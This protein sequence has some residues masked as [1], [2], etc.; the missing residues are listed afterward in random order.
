MPGA[1]A[2]LAP[3]EVLARRGAQPAIVV[4]AAGGGIQAAAWTA[5]VLAGLQHDAVQCHDDFDTSLLAISSVSGGSVGAMY[6]ADAYK[7]GHLP[8]MLRIDEEPAVK[9]AEA[10]SL[11]QVA[12]ALA[13]P[14]LTWTL[15]PFLKGLWLWP[16]HLVNGPL[17]TVDRGSALEDAWKRTP[18]L[19]N[20]TLDAWRR[21]LANGQRPAIIFNSTIAETGER[22]LFATTTLDMGEAA[23]RVD[24]GTSPRY[25]DADVNVVTAA[26]MSATFPYVS[27]A[28]RIQRHGVF[29]DEYHLVDGGYYDNYG[30]ATLT[31]WLDQGLRAPAGS[32]PSRILIIEIRSFPVG[33]PAPPDGRRG[34]VFEVAQPAETLYQVRGAGQLSHSN[35]D[36]QLT[37]ALHTDVERLVI[38]FPEHVADEADDL[39][40]PLSWHLTPTDRGRLRAAWNLKTN[41]GVRNTVHNFLSHA[42]VNDRTDQ[43]ASCLQ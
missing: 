12:W 32:R 28:A 14:D 33:E 40:P 42:N 26:R 38:T 19:S 1:A 25:K 2:S 21:D 41:L 18:T 6:I 36:V 10:S 7:Q 39:G 11:D 29:D 4:A 5:R 16:A 37:R 22:M 24:F 27:P 17:L 13:Y 20:A 3:A 34:W 8:P 30:T 35:V 15:L 23:G 9:A 43:I 31:E